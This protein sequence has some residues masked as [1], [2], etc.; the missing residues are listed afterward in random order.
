MTAGSRVARSTDK[1]FLNIFCSTLLV[2]EIIICTTLIERKSRNYVEIHSV[3]KK[4]VYCIYKSNRVIRHSF[5][6]KHINIDIRYICHGRQKTV[7]WDYLFFLQKSPS[8]RNVEHINPKNGQACKDIYHYEVPNNVNVAILL[9]RGDIAEIKKTD[10]F[11]RC[12]QINGRRM[13]IM[14]KNP[15]GI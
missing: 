5:I 1:Q 12:W 7:A 14:I 15:L 11:F 8:V 13:L 6:N 4:V 10:Y 3:L 9:F 2:H